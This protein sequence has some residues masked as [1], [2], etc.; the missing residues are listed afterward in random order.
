MHF[1]ASFSVPHPKFSDILR[2]SAGPFALFCAVLAFL[3]FL[4]WFLVLPRFTQVTVRGELLSSAALAV[5]VRSVREDLA[6]AQSKRDALILPLDQTPYAAL[7][8]EKIDAVAPGQVR[9]AVLGI[10][11]SLVPEQRQAVM[12]TS[13]V[14][15][16]QEKTLQLSGDVRH[17][18]LRSMTVLAQFVDAVSAL[19]AVAGVQ[20]PVFTR[21]QDAET[22]FHSPFTFR[23]TLQ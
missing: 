13:F 3:L 4:S 9:A 7:M 6:A 2:R 22:G 11:Q 15:M 5:H 18:G 17:V 12:L 10:A 16:P 21:E 14:F 20:H 23:V 8:Q 19:P 1:Q